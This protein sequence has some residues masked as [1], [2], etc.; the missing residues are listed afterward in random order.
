MFSFNGYGYGSGLFYP[1]FFLYLPAALMFFGL[2]LNVSYKLF[3]LLIIVLLI[4]SSYFTGK[5]IFKNRLAGV[6]SAIFFVTSQT[7]LTN[8]YI[9]CALGETLASIF[10]PIAV[11]ALYNIIYEKFSNPCLLV[12]AFIGLTYTHTITLFLAGLISLLVTLLN[13][14]KVFVL[15]KGSRRYNI[16]VILKMLFCVFATLSLSVSYWLPML[17]QFLNSKFYVND[18]SSRAFSQV[19]DCTVNTYTFLLKRNSVGSMFATAFITILLIG[20]LFVVDEKS[21]LFKISKQSI[22]LGTVLA[23][24]SLNIFKKI[25]RILNRTAITF[26]QFPWRLHVFAVTFLSLG[27]AGVITFLIK[28]N[29][30]RK[31][32]VLILPFISTICCAASVK[33][34]FLSATKNT[35]EFTSYTIHGGHEWLPLNTDVSKLVTPN[36]VYD[37]N[38]C[39]ITLNKREGNRISFLVDSESTYFDVPLLFYKGYSAYLIDKDSKRHELVVVKSVNNNLVR[40]LNENKLTGTIYVFYKGTEVQYISYALN[41]ISFLS[42]ITYF[43]I[44]KL[45]KCKQIKLYNVE[46]EILSV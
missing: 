21:K 38:D 44:V 39:D 7:V 40:V 1:D 5:Y 22:F 11:A 8:M 23:L 31:H 17:E 33:P 34:I 25:W 13:I 37:A 35:S 14:D 29:N 12:L 28:N 32:L 16:N 3:L 15:K 6:L 10:L 26:I 46:K 24:S 36:T 20:M 27:M 41:I 2:S 42:V 4:C 18:S 45:K 9:R 30:K 43:L 19:A